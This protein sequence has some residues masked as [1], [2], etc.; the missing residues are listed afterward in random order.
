MLP[1]VL[2]FLTLLTSLKYQCLI[3]RN[4][5]NDEP[6]D[7]VRQTFFGELQRIVRLNLPKSFEIHQPQDETVLLAHIRTCNAT[8]NKNGFWEYSTMK[9]LPHFV[10][11]KMIICVVGRVHDQGHWTFID[12]SGP[13]AHVEMA[14]LSSSSQCSDVTDFSTSDESDSGS[15]SSSESSPALGSSSLNDG[16]PMDLDTSGTGSSG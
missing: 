16:S 13:T 9:P 11:L 12:R 15:G 8:E 7:L 5:D 3:D 1:F 10:D 4:T 14:S 2:S 6:E